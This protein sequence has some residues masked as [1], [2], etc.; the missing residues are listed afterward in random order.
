MEAVKRVVYNE[1]SVAHFIQECEHRQL[2]HGM[3]EPGP[4]NPGVPICGRSLE[5]TGVSTQIG[6]TQCAQCRLFG[7]VN[8]QYNNGMA[9]QVALGMLQKKVHGFPQ[10]DKSA[11]AR[12]E[13]EHIL[14]LA[15]RC[16]KLCKDQSPATEMVEDC[17]FNLLSLGR[18]TEL[19]DMFKLLR[20]HAY[21][22]NTER[23]ESRQRYKFFDHLRDAQR[24][25]QE[26]KERG[27]AP[28]QPKPIERDCAGCGNQQGGGIF[29]TVQ[30]MVNAAVSATKAI[31]GK[32]AEQEEFERRK[33]ICQEC[34]LKDGDGERLYRNVSPMR[35]FGAT[36][37]C[38][39]PFVQMPVRDETV[40]GCGC[41]LEA[42][43]AAAKEH[44]PVGKW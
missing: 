22:E 11:N 31:A 40:D 25:Y 9:F 14:D 20:Q 4:D 13:R 2:D 17:L 37:H 6:P 3:K 23:G 43:W 8:E 41:M 26:A 12:T 38:G 35:P 34:D 33:A 15:D 36:P 5:L 24:T 18:I 30:A 44:C 1:V 42:K 16:L 19:E 21:D 32:K 28:P 7:P 27:M 39:A 29:A 10:W